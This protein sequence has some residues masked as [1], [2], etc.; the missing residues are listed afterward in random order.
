MDNED[1][2]DIII[3]ATCLLLSCTSHGGRHDVTAKTAFYM[4][5]QLFATPSP[6]ECLLQSTSGLRRTSP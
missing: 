4:G 5:T 3:A 2:D 1:D 6:G